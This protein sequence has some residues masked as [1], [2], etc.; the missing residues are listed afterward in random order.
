M[1]QVK[2]N[3]LAGRDDELATFADYVTRAPRWHDGSRSSTRDLARKTAML[4]TEDA[5]EVRVLYEGK[6]RPGTRGATDIGSRSRCRS[7][8]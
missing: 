1:R 2:Q 5:S 8:A 4:H 7:I 6:W 3:P